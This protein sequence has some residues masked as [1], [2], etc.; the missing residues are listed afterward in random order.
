MD[1]TA[2]T[3]LAEK[4]GQ[5]DPKLD[6]SKSY[7]RPCGTCHAGGGILELDREGNRYDKKLL[8]NPDLAESLNGDYYKSQW[9]KTG[10]IE[11]DCFICHFQNYDYLKRRE[12]IRTLNFKWATVAG[13]GI[14]EVIG[15]VGNGDQPEVQYNIRLFDENGKIVIPF[16]RKPMT[17]N[18]QFCHFS[19]DKA[20]RGTTFNDPVNTYPLVNDVHNMAGLQCIDCHY[21]GEDHNFAKGDDNH[22]KVRDDL[23]NTMKNCVDCHTEGYKGAPRLKHRSIRNDHLD[24]LSCQACHIPFVSRVPVGAT[25]NIT[26]HALKSLNLL[27]TEAQ[28]DKNKWEQIFFVEKTNFWKPIYEK[29]KKGRDKEAKIWPVNRILPIFFTNKDTDGIH[30]QLFTSETKDAYEAFCKK[31]NLNKTTSQKQ[32]ELEQI[33]HSVNDIKLMLQTLTENLKKNSRFSQINLFYHKGGFLYSLDKNGN[34]TKQK[35]ETWVGKLPP[36]SIS[37]NVAPINKALGA[38]GCDDCHS[39]KSDI[40]NAPIVTDLI[41]EDGE[42]EYVKSGIFIGYSS[43]TIALSKLYGTFLTIMPFLLTFVFIIF[44]FL[45]FQYGY[46]TQNKFQSV[47]WFTTHRGYHSRIILTLFFIFLGHIFI[48]IKTGMINVFF[49]IYNKTAVYSGAAG[50]VLMIVGVISF[51]LWTKNIR[52]IINKNRWLSRFIPDD[53]HVLSSKMINV[54][55]IFVAISGI[56]LLINIQYRLTPTVIFSTSIIHGIAAVILIIFL[57]L[58]IALKKCEE[59]N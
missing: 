24:K 27:Y 8:D 23:D 33:I 34:P 4:M 20:K 9:D 53:D 17:R 58:N 2:F 19:I 46:G 43:M 55:A 36:Y 32:I 52:L 39:E 11:V 54:S 7:R 3:F 59:R 16:I 6:P 51:F 40:F 13:S 47:E 22:S 57:L 45:M 37:H 1:L 41:G 31:S 21:G 48:F 30:Y 25:I 49:S 10:V 29:R 26:G 15:F 18:C 5:F 50:L 12:Q 14:G 38:N 42:T 44:L 28:K 56:I 35:D